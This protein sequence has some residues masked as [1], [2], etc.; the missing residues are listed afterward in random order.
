M[1]TARSA[2]RHATEE[3]RGRERREQEKS[4]PFRSSFSLFFFLDHVWVWIASH[5]RP[6]K[7]KGYEEKNLFPWHNAFFLFSD[8]GKRYFPYDTAQ[9]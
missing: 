8:G 9:K 5:E 6:Q 1:L 3:A 7:N 2:F 4:P